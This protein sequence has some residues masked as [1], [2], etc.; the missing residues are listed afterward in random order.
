[1]KK[2]GGKVWKGLKKRR[3]GEKE[4]EKEKKRKSVCVCAE[5]VKK[6]KV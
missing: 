6:R 2:R 5:S 3:K 1:M 4:R